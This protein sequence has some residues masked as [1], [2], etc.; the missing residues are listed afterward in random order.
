MAELAGQLLLDAAAST[1]HVPLS[2]ADFSAPLQDINH[3]MIQNN[4]ETLAN[5]C[6]IGDAMAAAVMGKD[7]WVRWLTTLV[8]AWGFH[9]F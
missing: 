1:Q 4:Y 8:W 2:P 5:T 6:L 9:F 7:G 3:P